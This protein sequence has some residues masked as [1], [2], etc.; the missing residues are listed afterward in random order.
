MKTTQNQFHPMRGHV[1]DG[2]EVMMNNGDVVTVR[3]VMAGWQL[4]DADGRPHGIATNSAH[5]LACVVT[6][7]P[8]EDLA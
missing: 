7:Y 3:A 1:C 6:S 8:S 5:V 2:C 4:M